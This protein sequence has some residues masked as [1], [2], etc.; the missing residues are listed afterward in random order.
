MVLQIQS[1]AFQRVA[2]LDAVPGQFLAWADSGQHQQLRRIERATAEHNFALG[3]DLRQPRRVPILD[4]GSVG[5][6]EQHTG[7]VG[8]TADSQVGTARYGFEIGARIAAARA[9]LLVRVV[10]THALLLMTVEIRIAS[11]PRLRRRADECRAQRIGIAS[12]GHIERTTLAMEGCLIRG[13][14]RLEMF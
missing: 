10:E 2:Q 7:N 12:L 3:A 1:H 4:P 11:V 8:A 5:A 14:L 6:F 9:V 13:H